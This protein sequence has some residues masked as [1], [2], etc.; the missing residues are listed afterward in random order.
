MATQYV[1][2]KKLSIIEPDISEIILDHVIPNSRLTNGLEK[3]QII[4]ATSN[5]D[6]DFVKN[7]IEGE[8]KVLF[9]PQGT[10]VIGD[11]AFSQ[12]TLNGPEEFA[13][14]LVAVHFPD[15]LKVI[16][17]EAFRDCIGL[18]ELKLPSSLIE[19]WGYS[20][21]GCTGLIEV[22]FPTDLPVVEAAAFQGCTALTTIHF[23]VDSVLKK[24]EYSVFEG[25]KSLTTV[26]LPN[27][28]N[29]IEFH[30]FKGCKSL[31][32]VTL[33]TSL[34][35]IDPCAFKGCRNLKTVYCTSEVRSLLTQAMQRKVQLL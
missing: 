7:Y 21:E 34:Q 30:A 32:T 9:I 25:C 24:L 26:T 2:V 31:T 13:S 17:C 33:P 16:E 4:I 35:K 8:G 27:S 23:P 19:L 22:H 29:K 14:K 5:K 12:S 11:N 18:R 28:L 1:L 15:S 10:T 6:T 3:G 20:F